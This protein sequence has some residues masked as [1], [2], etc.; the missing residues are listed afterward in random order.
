LISRCIKGSE[1]T[2]ELDDSAFVSQL[3]N[4][5]FV[6]PISKYPVVVINFILNVYKSIYNCIFS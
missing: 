1:S 2:V 6:E 4:L 3:L 5:S